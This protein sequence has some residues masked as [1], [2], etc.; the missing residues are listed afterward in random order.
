MRI[1]GDNKIILSEKNKSLIIFI[2]VDG[3][4]ANWIKAACETC[5]VDFNDEK[6]RQDI[7]DNDGNIDFLMP[8]DKLWPK[9]DKQGIDWWANLE[10]LPWAKDLYNKM[11]EISDEFCV[12]TS[13]SY[14]HYSAAG[15]V[16]WLDKNFSNNTEYLMGKNKHFCAK[17]NAILIDDSPKNIEKFNENGGNGFL[18]PDPFTLEDNDNIEEVLKELDEFVEEVKGKI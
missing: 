1:Q 4:L 3:V 10:V 7:K 18:W 14:S 12:L 9:I 2:D 6:I 13:P 17:E 16:I 11:K 8:N 5:D 15:K